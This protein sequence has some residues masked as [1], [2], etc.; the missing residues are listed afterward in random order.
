MEKRPFSTWS[1]DGLEESFGLRQIKAI[2]SLESWLAQSAQF[3]TDAFEKQTLARLRDS[4]NAKADDWNEIELSEY[5]IGPVLSLVNFNTDDFSI[6][7]ER[8]ISGIVGDYEIFGAPDAMI[9]KGRRKPKLPYFCF[10][11]YKREFEPKGDPAA[12]ALAAMLVAQEM[13][14]HRLPVY[15]MYVA[16]RN[17]YFMTLQ[18]KEYAISP[19]FVAVL[20]DHLIQ[21]MRILKALKAIV[22]ELVKL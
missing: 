14:G 12:Q 18:E 10:H 15:G 8:E 16:G 19:P 13:N 2:A 6:F 20:E 1:K 22:I 17:W 9:A 4:L 5:F 3:E 21:I 11:E 7:S